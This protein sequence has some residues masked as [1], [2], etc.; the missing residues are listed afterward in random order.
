[1]LN[2]AIWFSAL[3]FLCFFVAGCNI[4]LSRSKALSLIEKTEESSEKLAMAYYPQTAYFTNEDSIRGDFARALITL[5]YMDSNGMLTTKGEGKKS[6]WIEKRIPV[7]LGSDVIQYEIP[8]GEREIIEVTG[9][10]KPSGIEENE[11]VVQFSWR[12]RPS[13]EIGN[14]MKLDE[15]N[16]SGA[17]LFQKYDDGWR[18]VRIAFQ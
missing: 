10:S 6:D 11:S 7:W 1:M 15:K 2:K 17:A 16:Y 9:I 12:W 4:G 5:G 13:N 18:I 14:E 3:A 8:V